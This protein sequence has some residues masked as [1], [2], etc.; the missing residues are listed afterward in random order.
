MAYSRLENKAK[1]CDLQRN[2][3][4]SIIP[5]QVYL[6][7]NEPY[8]SLLHCLFCVASGRAAS[9]TRVTKLIQAH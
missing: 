2:V 8:M 5:L 7:Y 6:Y 9:E 1:L 4:P 3:Y